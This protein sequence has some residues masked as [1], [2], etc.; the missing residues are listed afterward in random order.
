MTLRRPADLVAAGLL[1]A[2]RLASLERV[3][4]RY[5]V[6]VTPE[7]A[8]LI[9]TPDDPIAASSCLMRTNS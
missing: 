2:E 4:E 6:A 1:P 8:G 7:V 3:A 5:A 9:E